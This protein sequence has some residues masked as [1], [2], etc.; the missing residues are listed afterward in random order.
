MHAQAAR[1]ALV[2]TGMHKCKRRHWYAQVHKSMH[3]WY[4]QVHKG[5]HNW[6][7]Q[8]VHKGMHKGMHK[9]TRGTHGH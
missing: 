8:Q 2:G 9:C 7:V 4:A 3:N 6:Y 5:M 1:Q